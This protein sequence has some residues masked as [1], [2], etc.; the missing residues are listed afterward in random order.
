VA[1]ID[2]AKIMC[3]VNDVLIDKGLYQKVEYLETV[4]ET[5]STYD[6]ITGTD[7]K[8]SSKL[9]IFD[10]VLLSEDQSNQPNNV[11]GGSMKM[12]VIPTNISFIP[13]VDQMYV[14]YGVRWQVLNLDLSP[15]EAIFTISLRRK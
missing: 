4:K 13:E 15:Q 9:H 2:I 11:Y 14:I 8:E 1:G 12:L 6:P 10:A 7:S 3:Q 5:N